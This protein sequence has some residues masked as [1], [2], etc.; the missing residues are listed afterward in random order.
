MALIQIEEELF[1]E[2]LDRASFLRKLFVQL[3]ARLRNKGVDDWLTMEQVCEILSI[4]DT[5]VR[6]LKRSGRIGYIK[7]GKTLRFH[8]GDTHSLLERVA[9][10]GYESNGQAG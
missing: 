9:K 10:N 6:S 2:I 3:Y 5:K 4:S 1:K 8:A 7:C